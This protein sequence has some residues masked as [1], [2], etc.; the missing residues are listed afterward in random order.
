MNRAQLFEV[1]GWTVLHSLW[2][3]GLVTSTGLLVRMALPA[4]RPGSRYAV[5]LMTVALLS[6]SVGFVFQHQV[7]HLVIPV[8]TPDAVAVM[9]GDSFATPVTE[10]AESISS[11]ASVAWL[12]IL[13]FLISC[14]R[15]GKGSLEARRIRTQCNVVNSGPHWERLLALARRYG[16]RRCPTLAISDVIAS[17]LVVG[18]I[19]PMIV[20]PT[21]LLIGW[22]PDQVEMAMMHELAHVR[23]FDNF[24]ALAVRVLGTIL[25]FHPG[26]WLLQRQLLRD[27]ECCCDAFVVRMSRSPRLYAETLLSLASVDGRKLLP[28][29]AMAEHDLVGRVR[30]ILNQEVRM[31]PITS[32][33][34]GWGGAALCALALVSVIPAQKQEACPRESSE[35]PAQA[36]PQAIALVDVITEPGSEHAVHAIK[37]GQKCT[38]CHAKGTVNAKSN[39]HGA[40]TLE[41]LKAGVQ[42]SRETAAIDAMDWIQEEPGSKK[43][44]AISKLRKELRRA[45]KRIEALEAEIRSGRSN[46][47]RAM[48]WRHVGP[49]GATVDPR[50]VIVYPNP[51][52]WKAQQKKQDRLDATE[53]YR[54]KELYDAW[55]LERARSGATKGDRKEARDTIIYL[56]D[57]TKEES[58]RKEATLWSTTVDPQEEKSPRTGRVRWRVLPEPVDPQNRSADVDRLRQKNKDL[59]DAIIEL[60]RKLSEAQG[61]RRGASQFY[62]RARGEYRLNAPKRGVGEEVPGDPVS[63]EKAARNK[64]RIA[65]LGDMEA[66][67]QDHVMKGDYVKALKLMEIQKREMDRL[68]KRNEVKRV[69]VREDVELDREVQLRRNEVE[70][71]RREVDLSRVKEELKARESVER[72]QKALDLLKAKELKLK[73]EESV[74]RDL[75][76]RMKLP[77][78]GPKGI[79]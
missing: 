2:V 47:P 55:L 5:V 66:A 26:M 22:S 28:S 37:M 58:A 45:M 1:I 32:R 31:V 56:N 21:A 74:N 39:P 62:E 71:L 36:L 15:L 24:V 14:V 57:F 23:R 40:F 35:C 50:G 16:L 10:A 20:F 72:Y 70:K 54:K 4:V 52:V 46:N 33:L 19:K 3:G 30:L 43:G 18:T 79:R 42:K 64:A 8:E 38:D 68:L 69:R 7:A 78:T 27:R 34:L 9:P 60:K 53:N 29:A 17:P 77:K 73:R 61:K 48:D 11:V 41:W 13:G 44:K 59:Q 6:A 67:A 51:H 65:A 49:G 12:W 63:K 25:F 75:N 76:R